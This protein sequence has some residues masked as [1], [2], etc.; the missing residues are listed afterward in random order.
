MDWAS[1]AV[2]RFPLV[3]ILPV[4]STTT[5]PPWSPPPP[6]PPIF[7]ASAPAPSSVAPAPMAKPAVPPAPPTDCASI[8]NE[9]S[10]VVTRAA[11]LIT[12]TLPPC[13]PAPPLPPTLTDAAAV[14]DKATPIPK[15]PI[16]PP[17]PTDCARIALE[18]SPF[19]VI[20]P[21]FV[22]VNEPPLP[23]APP[24]A[25]TLTLPAKVCAAAPLIVYPALPPPPPMD[26]ARIPN[27]RLSLVWILAQL[28]TD[29]VPPFPPVPPA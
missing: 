29:T 4:F 21:S 18:F 13:L 22:T 26:C 20:A 10:L 2:D 23:A 6:K 11:L 19:V 3:N 25:P 8:P 28:V 12:V 17:P 14:R 5:A 9:L 16:P 27:E 15:P 7:T 1:R 24:F